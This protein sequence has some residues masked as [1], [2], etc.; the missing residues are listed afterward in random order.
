MIGY[1]EP[2]STFLKKYLHYFHYCVDELESDRHIVLF[3][4]VGSAIT[5]YFDTEFSEINFQKFVSEE[6]KG[7]NGVILQTNRIDPVEIIERGKQHRITS[8]FNPLGVNHFIKSSLEDL[9]KDQ[10]PSR[11]NIGDTDNRYAEFVITLS[12]ISSIESRVDAIEKFFLSIYQNLD[13]RFM[14]TALPYF[15]SQMRLTA[16]AEH[17][18]MSIKTMDRF[19]KKHMGVTPVQFRNIVQ[20]RNSLCVKFS[21][22]HRS[23]NDLAFQAEYYDLPYMMKVYKKFTKQPMS[24]FFD[25]L[26]VSAGGKYL[27]QTNQ[28]VD[29]HAPKMSQKYKG[30]H[31]TEL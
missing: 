18:G 11:I 28:A 9:V 5:F 15:H 21:D 1:S 19:F 8:V 16:I 17:S 22:A 31:A 10:N 27:F 2:R 3:P 25:R 24:E 30:R 14:E 13:D 12:N 7:C 6:K 26:Q 20:F 29:E 4:N 23:L